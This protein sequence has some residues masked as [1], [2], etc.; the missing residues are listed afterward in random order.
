MKKHSKKHPKTSQIHQKVDLE[1]ALGGEG[2]LF[3]GGACLFLENWFWGSLSGA[4]LGSI[5]EAILDKN[6]RQNFGSFEKFLGL[7]FVSA[8]ALWVLE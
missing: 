4:I 3:S 5:L 7:N 6:A 1:G 8:L 2:G